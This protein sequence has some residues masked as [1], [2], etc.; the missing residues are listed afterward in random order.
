MQGGLMPA[1]RNVIVTASGWREGIVLAVKFRS[2]QSEK[3]LRE[4]HPGS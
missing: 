2:P 4:N 1:R 3:P